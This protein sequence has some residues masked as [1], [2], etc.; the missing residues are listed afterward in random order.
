MFVCIRWGLD[1][2]QQSREGTLMGWEL[3][4]EA[5]LLENGDVGK[6]VLSYHLFLH[7]Y[8]IKH[9]DILHAVVRC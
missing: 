5:G 2:R 3:V 9:G 7:D 6:V 4:F 8:G 1:G